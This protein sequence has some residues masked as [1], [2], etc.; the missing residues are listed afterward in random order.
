MHVWIWLSHRATEE[1]EMNI[2]T[3]T[4]SRAKALDAFEAY[5][6]SVET[7][8]DAELATIM[9]GYKALAKGQEVIDLFDVLSAAGRDEEGRPHLAICRAHATRV[10]VK[11]DRD[12]SGRFSLEQSPN[13]RASWSVV[14]F[15]TGTFNRSD[16]WVNASA[17]VP[18]VPPQYRPKFKLSNYHILWEADWKRVPVDPILLKHLSRSLYAVLAS[19]DLTEIERAVLRG[20]G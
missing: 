8:Q 3:I 15:P 2:A 9:R 19:W 6:G 17:V 4:M 18:I 11:V 1:E 16:Q 7:R 20:R 10:F 5:R 14:R 13:W 12:G